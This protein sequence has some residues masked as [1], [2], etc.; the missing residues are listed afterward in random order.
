MRTPSPSHS[1]LVWTIAAIVSFTAAPTL[2]A[3]DDHDEVLPLTAVVKRSPSFG[4]GP[5]YSALDPYCDDIDNG[6]EFGDAQTR[7]L[8]YELRHNATEQQ[9]HN[10]IQGL[11]TAGVLIYGEANFGAHVV[12]GQT[13]SLW[14]TD[15]GI[16][17]YQFQDQ[18]AGHLLGFSSA[19]SRSQGQGTIIA[20]IDSGVDPTHE[21][22]G[23]PLAPWQWDFVDNDS[24]PLDAGD[25]IDNDLDGLMDEGVGHGTYITSLVRLAAPQAQLMHLRILDDEGNANSFLLAS[26]IQA[27][28]EHGA[29][30]VNVSASSDFNSSVLAQAIANAKAAGVIVIAAMGNDGMVVPT[31][32]EYPASYSNCYAVCSTDDLDHKGSFSNWGSCADFCAPGVS[33]YGSDGAYHIGTS[34]L[35]AIPG[36][37]YGH[38]NGTSLSA[39]FLSGAAALVR[40][41]YPEWPNAQVPTNQIAQ[42]VMDI[43]AQTAVSVDAINPGYQGMLG[44]GRIDAAAAVLLGPPAPRAADINSDHWVNALDLAVLL[45]NWGS[46]TGQPCAGDFDGNGAV[47]GIDLSVLLSN[48][49]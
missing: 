6:G 32:E 5:V 41:Q 36:E 31:I 28:V 17:N 40:A 14:V 8:K 26:A 33:R 20:V 24:S 27:A 37:G 46:C 45:A 44:A 10:A 30:V 42:T 16:T 38:W 13:G 12:G 39:A 18:Y 7:L 15:V 43:L 23:G 47:D 1:S 19:H 49:D 21:A 3:D 9:V 29:H 11:V 22:V 48:W 34:V 2:L 25:G 35:G 4:F